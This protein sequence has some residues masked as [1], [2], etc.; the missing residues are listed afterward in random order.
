MIAA[1]ARCRIVSGG[2]SGSCSMIGAMKLAITS[3]PNTTAIALF[4]VVIAADMLPQINTAPR[5]RWAMLWSAFTAKIPSS[6]PFE[7]MPGMKPRM[8][9]AT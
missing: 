7:V 9:I 3:T 6:S 2:L 5:T 1:L 8:P 4:T